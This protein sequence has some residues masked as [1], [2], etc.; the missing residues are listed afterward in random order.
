[1]S[2]LRSSTESLGEFPEQDGFI[3][4]A[5][6]LRIKRFRITNYGDGRTAIFA[7][8][9]SITLVNSLILFKRNTPSSNTSGIVVVH[10]NHVFAVD[11]HR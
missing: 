6:I 3:T 11:K 4:N 7:L 9:V 5:N 8:A 1:M 2:N 10:D